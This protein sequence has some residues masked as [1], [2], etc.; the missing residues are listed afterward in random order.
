MPASVGP[1]AYF[2]Q[3]FAWSAEA[4][5]DGHRV[6]EALAAMA[7]PI[8]LGLAAGKSAPGYVVAL[9]AMLLAAEPGGNGAAQGAAKGH[10]PAI[11][12]LSV[13][14]AI[15]LAGGIAHLAFADVAMIALAAAAATLVN[16]SRPAAVGGIRFI[17]LLVLSLGLVG[18]HGAH[19]AGAALLFG[20]GALWRMLLRLL[21]ARRRPISG[22][23]SMAAPAAAATPARTPTPRQR[24]IH[25][26]RMLRTLEGWQ[27]PLR[28]AAGLAAACLLRDFRP[29]HH[30][31]WAVISVALMTPRAL[32]HLPVHITQ[33]AIGTLAGVALS[34][35]ILHF[36]PGDAATALL[37]CLL[38]TGAPLLRAGNYAAYCVLST[39]LI[40]LAMDGGAAPDTTV[41]A[42]RLTATLA[43]SAIVIGASL[44]M[45]AVQ[46]LQK[47]PL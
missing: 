15:S 38:G 43:G 44:L 16:Y 18:S 25:F 41:L 27:Y 22:E 17:V 35:A 4:R 20:V 28:L 8:L 6:L 37:V 45:D 2:A 40:L 10:A 34:G 5:L 1:R 46:K 42:D 14:L 12:L 36:A 33:R 26:G 30:Y 32:E 7:L 39:P 11:T 9:G 47:G 3:V 23:A 24:R 29:S 31:D 13:L 21:A 19:G